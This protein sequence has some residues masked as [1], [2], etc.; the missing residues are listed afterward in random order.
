MLCSLFLKGD[1]DEPKPNWLDAEK[2]IFRKERDKDGDGKLNKARIRTWGIKVARSAAGGVGAFCLGQTQTTTTHEFADSEK[3]VHVSMNI[4]YAI[5][6]KNFP[7]G[8]S[9]E[10]LLVFFR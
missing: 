7:T 6:K 5:L 9:L 10:I 3:S 4:L 8:S 1:Y 2:E